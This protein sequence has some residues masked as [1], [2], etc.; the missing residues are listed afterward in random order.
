MAVFKVASKN[1][2]SSLV[3]KKCELSQW[4]E[5][6]NY[7]DPSLSSICLYSSIF[8]FAI[9]FF[10]ILGM[11]NHSKPFQ[12]GFTQ[13]R[14]LYSLSLQLLLPTSYFSWISRTSLESPWFGS[15]DM[16]VEIVLCFLYFPCPICPSPRYQWDT[17]EKV[18]MV[19][20]TG[21]HG[22]TVLFCLLLWPFWI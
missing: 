5:W 13:T 1:Y 19:S 6:Y 10:V 20:S 9:S 4:T 3:A 21:K 2:T 15:M 11:Y 18:A 12:V 16:S 7:K 14:F 22:S 8:W 17:A